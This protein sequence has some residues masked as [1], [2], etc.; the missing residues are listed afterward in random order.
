MTEENEK[1]SN[2]DVEN[3][4]EKKVIE[5]CNIIFISNFRPQLIIR[6][7]YERSA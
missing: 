1:L 4:N 2:I 3:L 7:I 5:E 6:I